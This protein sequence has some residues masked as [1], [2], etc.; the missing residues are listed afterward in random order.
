M[1]RAQVGHE[2]LQRLRERTVLASFW[3]RL[4]D[5][6]LLA[7]V[8]VRRHDQ[9]SRDG[10]GDGR[11]VVRADQVQAHVDARCA[12]GGGDH[13]VVVDVVDVGVDLDLGKALREPF[14]VLPMSRRPSTIEQ[15]GAGEG[16]SAGAD[17][18]DPGSLVTSGLQP[19]TMIVPARSRTFSEY[20]ALTVI[21]P[22][23]RIVPD[24]H[25]LR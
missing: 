17:R 5:E 8:P 6:L 21:P 3:D 9:A 22:V 12:T 25:S 24:R 2:P 16:E 4:S 14:S 18:R 20:G 19:G 1:L 11:T 13:T 15:A 10:I 23:A 7:T